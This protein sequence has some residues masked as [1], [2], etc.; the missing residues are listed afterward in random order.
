MFPIN[1]CIFLGE[2]ILVQNFCNLDHFSQVLKL[3]VEL[4]SA[5]STIDP[6]RHLNE[7]KVVCMF[8][9]NCCRFYSALAGYRPPIDYR[10]VPG[11][12]SSCMIPRYVTCPTSHLNKH[13][14][15]T[16]R[17]RTDKTNH[18]TIPV[19]HVQNHGSGQWSPQ[20]WYVLCM[21]FQRNMTI[22]DPNLT[23]AILLGQNS[24]Q[25]WHERMVALNVGDVEQLGFAVAP[26]PQGARVDT[27]CITRGTSI[28]KFGSFRLLTGNKYM[29]VQ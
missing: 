24:G 21:F 29:S 17:A 20:F 3:H 12:S 11:I 5:M 22:Q 7:L 26:F 15:L 1:Y 23:I 9:V 6:K 16:T 28:Y 8:Q 14:R 19:N 18:N 25:E 4:K 2:I 27:G 10:R 13:G